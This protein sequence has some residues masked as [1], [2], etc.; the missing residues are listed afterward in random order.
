[1]EACYQI[2]CLVT[3]MALVVHN[4]VLHLQAEDELDAREW[5]EAIAGVISC[6]INS[7]I[8]PMPAKTQGKPAKPTHSRHSSFAG[9]GWCQVV[10]CAGNKNAA[11]DWHYCHCMIMASKAQQLPAWS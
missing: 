11:A 8:G 6:L 7:N 4:Q 9:G 1:M 3:S 2:L 5:M 10:T